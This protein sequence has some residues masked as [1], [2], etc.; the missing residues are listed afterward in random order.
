MSLEEK[1]R[2]K[3]CVAPMMGWTDRHTRYFLRLISRHARLYTEMITADAILH[4]DREVLLGFHEDEH[5]VALQVGGSDPV[6]LAEVARIGEDYGYDEINLNIGCPSRSVQSGRFG[7]CLMKEPARV[8]DCMSSIMQAVKIDVTIKC[9]IGVDEQDSEEALFDFI[10][11]VADAGC[12]IFVIHARKAWLSGLSPKE[13]RNIPLLDYSL[14]YR[15][16][17]TRP[18]LNVILNGGIQSLEASLHH[19]NRIDGVMLGREV[20]KNPYVLADVDRRFFSVASKI[21]SREEII[22]AFLPYVEK[23]V[24]HGLRMDRLTRPLMGL[25]H[26]QPRGKIWRRFLSEEAQKPMA[27]T[28]TLRV[29]LSYMSS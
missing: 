2:F 18:E 3:F 16:K 24:H 29:A 5:P 15:L 9:R 11:K 22:Q 28:E 21:L 12:R 8:A 10:D 26:A 6:I 25:Y 27:R 17:K 7:A 19:L 13:N 20:Y 23:M 14:V 4:G 1:E